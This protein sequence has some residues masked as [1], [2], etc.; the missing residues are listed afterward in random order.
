MT[1]PLPVGTL[2]T[3]LMPFGTIKMRPSLEGLGAANSGFALKEFELSGI[4]IISVL[5]GNG[6]WKAEP[7]I[8]GTMGKAMKRIKA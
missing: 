3:Y 1:S 4:E 8:A 5:R 7:G 2:G 6:G